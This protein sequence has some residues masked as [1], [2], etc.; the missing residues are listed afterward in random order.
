[1]VSDE[2]FFFNF[3]THRIAG[4]RELAACHLYKDDDDYD[5]NNNNN[6]IRM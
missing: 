5:N 3:R 6:K 4:E 2:T 1:M